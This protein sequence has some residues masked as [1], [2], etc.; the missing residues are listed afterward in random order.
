MCIR[1]WEDVETKNSIVSSKEGAIV[2]ALEVHDRRQ[3]PKTIIIVSKWRVENERAI[4]YR[5]NIFSFSFLNI[6]KN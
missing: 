4:Q 1:S 2:F 6:A 3:R 5:K